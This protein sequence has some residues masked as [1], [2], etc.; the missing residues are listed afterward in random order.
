MTDYSYQYIERLKFAQALLSD[1]N[2][3]ISR[4]PSPIHRIANKA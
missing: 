4:I 2:L 3:A 1:L